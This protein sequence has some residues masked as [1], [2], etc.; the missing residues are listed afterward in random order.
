MKWRIEQIEQLRE[1]IGAATAKELHVI[2]TV[3][4]PHLV[5]IT[6]KERARLFAACNA[7]AEVL[8]S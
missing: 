4:I 5:G 3:D 1:F 7:R 6:D 8:V 2:R